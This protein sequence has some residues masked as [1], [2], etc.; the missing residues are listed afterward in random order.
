[1]E[2][3]KRNSINSWNGFLIEGGENAAETP[4]DNGLG[5]T[6]LCEIGREICQILQRGRRSSRKGKIKPGVW[7]QEKN[8]GVHLQ[9]NFSPVTIIIIT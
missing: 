6:E 3:G 1:M 7:I 2:D 5:E 9:C 8:K 4:K